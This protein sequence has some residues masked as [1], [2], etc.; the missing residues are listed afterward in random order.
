MISK[1]FLSQLESDLGLQKGLATSARKYRSELVKLKSEL[2]EENSLKDSGSGDR[3]NSEYEMLLNEKDAIIAE[4]LSGLVS[5]GSIDSI[6][7]NIEA[8]S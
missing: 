7:L 2:L 6:G 4:Y 8:M 1:T 5:N 3:T